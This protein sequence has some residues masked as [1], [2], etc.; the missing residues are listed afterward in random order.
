MG[1]VFYL[2]NVSLDG[3]VEDVNGSIAFTVPAADV[4]GLA[5][6]QITAGIGLTV[7]TAAL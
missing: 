3:Y 2:M 7:R 1:K 5:T 6:E 4:F